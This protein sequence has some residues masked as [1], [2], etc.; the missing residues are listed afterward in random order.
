MLLDVNTFGSTSGTSEDLI[1]A[2]M[3]DIHIDSSSRS[4]IAGSSTSLNVSMTQRRASSDAERTDTHGTLTA[5]PSRVA[6]CAPSNYGF[7]R[8]KYKNDFTMLGLLQ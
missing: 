2:L 7:I 8:H 5:T 6:S 1:T 3:G 4:G